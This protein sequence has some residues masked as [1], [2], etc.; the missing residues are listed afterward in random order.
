[1][2]TIRD[3]AK[4]AGVSVATVSRVINQSGYVNTKTRAKVLHAMKHLN[5]KPST[6]ARGLAGKKMHFIA[7]ILP[8]IS[9]PFF[10]E[11]ARAVE[12]VAQQHDFTVF[13]CNSDNDDNK[14]ANYIEVLKKKNV[15]GL[16]ISSNTFNE[17]DIES[18]RDD[19]IPVVILD[20]SIINE[21]YSIV[22]SKNREGAR[23][24][25]H[26]L[27]EHGCRKIAHISGPQ[28]TDT[29]RE[30]LYGYE[31]VVKLFSWYDPTLIEE[32]Q[33]QIEGSD[34]ALQNLLR[35]HPDIDGIFAGN[36]LMALGVLK[37]LRKQGLRVP[38]DIAVC[39]F[40]GIMLTKLTQPT[41]TTVAQ[42]IYQMG[43]KAAKM[44]VQ[45]IRGEQT[46][47]QLFEFEVKLI[48]GESTQRNHCKNS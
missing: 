42:P 7:L 25:V 22:R 5:Y 9:N 48:E 41:I 1:M 47:S 11:L 39:G 45:K 44:L 14:E 34:I 2:P 28:K 21:G 31:D 29:G 20:R 17:K 16:I 3:V 26:H 19:K 10:S 15:D 4:M 23:L 43:A 24:A 32:G 18:F 13:L 6:V 8:D 35:R 37:E 36:D 12:D 38:T 33:F 30:R 46:G 27:L 40:D